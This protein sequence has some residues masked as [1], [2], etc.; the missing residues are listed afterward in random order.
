MMQRDERRRKGGRAKGKKVGYGVTEYSVIKVSESER[1][2]TE[3]SW[4]NTSSEERDRGGKE[5]R[6]KKVRPK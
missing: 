4:R 6:K 1:N 3:E 2:G 5:D